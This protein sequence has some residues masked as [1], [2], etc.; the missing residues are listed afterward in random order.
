MAKSLEKVDLST[1][2]FN[3]S[4]TAQGFWIGVGGN[5]AVEDTD[6]N[7]ETIKNIDGG[8]YVPAAGIVKVLKTGTTAS[9]IVAFS[10]Q[11]ITE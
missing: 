8:T 5:L 2:D 9:E 4:F 6:G 10:K 3:L 11:G 7:Q 1:S